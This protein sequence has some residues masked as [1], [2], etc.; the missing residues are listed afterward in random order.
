MEPELISTLLNVVMG[1]MA[2]IPALAPVIIMFRNKSA[3]IEALLHVVNMAMADG[4]IDADECRMIAD[5][6]QDL[7]GT[8]IIPQQEELI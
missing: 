1:L 3:K 2:G 8:S 4:E 6:V 7:L 5:R